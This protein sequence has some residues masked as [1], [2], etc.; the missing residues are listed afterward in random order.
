MLKKQLQKAKKWIQKKI[1]TL[2]Q[3][4][5]QMDLHGRKLNYE[6]ISILNKIEATYYTGDKH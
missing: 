5:K 2:E 6:G 4:L 1:F 3:I